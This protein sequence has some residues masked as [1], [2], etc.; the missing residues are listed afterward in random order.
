MLNLYRKENTWTMKLICGISAI[1][2]ILV[3]FFGSVEY[4]GMEASGISRLIIAF[5]G[6]FLFGFIL[7]LP[8]LGIIS[9]FA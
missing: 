6:S 2:F 5:V 7:G 9:L 1:I 4:K 3:Y 8:T